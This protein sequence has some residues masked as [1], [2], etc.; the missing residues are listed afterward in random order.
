MSI[1]TIVMATAIAMTIAKA[2][3]DTNN[4]NKH[5]IDNGNKTRS[6]GTSNRNE[7]Y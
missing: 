1:I 3:N 5:N 2:F 7:Q 4:D 6:D